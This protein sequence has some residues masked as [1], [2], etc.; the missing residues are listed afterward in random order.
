MTFEDLPPGWDALPLTDHDLAGD[1]LDLF[2]SARDREV[3]CVFFLLCDERAR[4]RQ[5]LAVRLDPSDRERQ[6]DQGDEAEVLVTR[7]DGLLGSEAAGAASLIMAVARP[8]YS[9]INDVDR[10]WHEAVID[11]T[12]RRSVPLL[13]TYVVTHQ[14]VVRLPDPLP[15]ARTA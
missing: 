2:V 7:L 11:L 6:G 15:P 4:L 9:A 12:R 13:G 3:G 8:G 10:R 14:D 1:V 5:P